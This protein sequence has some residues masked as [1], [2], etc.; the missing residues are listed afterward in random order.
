[1]VFNFSQIYQGNDDPSTIVSHYL[2]PVIT[3]RFIRINALSCGAIT[4][5]LRVEF[6]GTYEGNI[7]W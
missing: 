4:C 5:A 3:S 7:H 2:W 6:I 1:M